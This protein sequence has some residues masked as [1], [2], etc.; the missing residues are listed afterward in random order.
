[1]DP[2]VLSVSPKIDSKSKLFPQPTWPTIAVND[3]DLISRVIFFNCSVVPLPARK[4]AFSISMTLSWFSI[5]KKGSYL[6]VIE[7]EFP[8]ILDGY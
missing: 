5:W 6:A 2:I 1:M 3:P 8:R 7:Y 4:D